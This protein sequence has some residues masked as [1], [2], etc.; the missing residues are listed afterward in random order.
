MNKPATK[1]M[2]TLDKLRSLSS[3]KDVRIERINIDDLIPDPNQPRSRFRPVDGKVDP[4][5]MAELREFADDINE[6]GQLQPILYRVVDGQKMII[7]GERRWRAKRINRDLGRPNSETVDGIL[8]QDLTSENLRLAQLSENLHRDDLTDIETAVYIKNLLEEFPDLKKKDIGTVFNKNSQY[9][10]RIL[11]ML[12]PQWNDVISSGA[13]QFASL[14]EQYR[15]LPEKQKAEL[16]ELFNLEKRPL[17]SGDIRAAKARA[18]AEDAARKV[19]SA[20]HTHDAGKTSANDPATEHEATT[21][22]ASAGSEAAVQPPRFPSSPPAGQVTLD[23]DLASE[24]SKFLAQ[25]A[26]EGE[27]YRPTGDTTA[28]AGTANRPIKD[29]GGEAI[30][31]RGPAALSSAI[32]EKREIRMTLAQLEKLLSRGALEGKGHQVSVMLPVDEVKSALVKMGAPLPE[33]D[34]NVVL[35]LLEAV[36]KM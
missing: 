11:A 10:S 17:T 16:I 30:I 20:Q 8:R 18:E 32:H 21:G 35:N 34:S 22:S 31:P 13:I 3:P 33:D 19:E 7:A 14:L 36:N 1:P 6:R 28:N 15:P 9:V 29:T 12:D 26:P 27:T 24:V 4:Q 2:G 5:V 25:S 23:A